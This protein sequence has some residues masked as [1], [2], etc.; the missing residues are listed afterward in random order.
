MMRWSR[1][2]SSVAARSATCSSSA[3]R[4]RALDTYNAA[5]RHSAVPCKRPRI[6]RLS[7]SIGSAYWYAASSSAMRRGGQHD[8]QHDQHDHQQELHS[9]GEQQRAPAKSWRSSRQSRTTCPA[10]RPP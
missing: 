10:D 7:S 3:P 4:S 1:G 6:C 8:H 2:G 9:R 5:A